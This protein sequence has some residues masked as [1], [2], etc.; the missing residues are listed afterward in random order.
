[1]VL[2]ES[3]ASFTRS[4][5]QKLIREHRF[6]HFESGLAPF[7]FRVKHASDFMSKAHVEY[8]G[9]TLGKTIRRQD[10]SYIRPCPKHPTSTTL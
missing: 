5:M 6:E 2:E 1:M 3:S 9:T 4:R 8:S 7:E 10:E